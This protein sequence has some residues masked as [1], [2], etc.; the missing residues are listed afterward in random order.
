MEAGPS[1]FLTPDI[2]QCA[3]VVRDLDEA[4]ARFAAELGIGPWT[5]YKLEPPL[6]KG[7][8]KD[9]ADV[10]FS[11][12]H[13]LAW[14]GEMQFELVQPLAGPSIFAEHLERHG[15]G[16]HHV[17]K[18]VADHPGAVAAALAAGFVELQA[19]HGFGAEGDGAFAYFRH[20]ALP[21][22]VE[23]I[24]APR[25]RIEPEFVYPRSPA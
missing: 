20:P 2:K 6:L 9:G 21:L 3:L 19:A 10:E 22:I 13:A 4:V 25:V 16:L 11:L 1:P 15:E 18:Y 12:R 8:R 7:M 17:G 5:A 14:Q 23:L 24:S